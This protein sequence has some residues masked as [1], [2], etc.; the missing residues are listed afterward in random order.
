MAVTAKIK[1][2]KKIENLKNNQMNIGGLLLATTTEFSQIKFKFFT[3]N[4]KWFR[5]DAP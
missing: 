4:V 3:Y 2:L 1:Q 5:C